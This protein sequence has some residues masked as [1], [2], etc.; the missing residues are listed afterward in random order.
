ME[1][2]VIIDAQK[3]KFEVDLEHLKEEY[4]A[5]LVDQEALYDES[6]VTLESLFNASLDAQKEL[7]DQLISNQKAEYEQA[8]ADAISQ[9]NEELAIQTHDFEVALS[10]LEQKLADLNSKLYIYEYSTF[11]FNQVEDSLIGTLS[12]EL[13]LPNSTTLTVEGIKFTLRHPLTG[14]ISTVN[15]IISVNQFEDISGEFEL[16]VEFHGYFEMTIELTYIDSIGDQGILTFKLPVMYKVDQVNFAW[17]HATMPVLLFASDLLNNKYPGYTYVEIERAATYDFNKLP[18]KALKYPLAVSASGGNYTQTQIPNFYTNVTHG[19]SNKMIEWMKELYSI[20]PNTNFKILGVDNDLTVITSSILSG[21]PFERLS[22][23][24]YTDGS[25]TTSMINS[26]FSTLSQFNSL[27]TLFE[28]WLNG[29]VSG[30][31]I[32]AH[33]QSYYVLTSTKLD[34]FE[35]VVNSISGWNL[36]HDLMELIN[37]ELNVRVLSVSDAFGSLETIGKLDELEYL[38]KT[39][40]GS[41]PNESMMAY[42]TGNPVKNLLILGTSPTGEVNAQ[43]ASFDK[44]LEKIVELYGDEYKIFYKGH[45]RYPSEPQRV[46]LFENNNVIEL[47]N[48]IPVETLML[49]YENVYVGGYNGTSFQSS[50]KDQTVFLFGTQALIKGNAT[51]K[52]LIETTDI[53]SNTVYL[54]VDSNGE[55]VVQ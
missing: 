20:N 49:L 24:I 30:S 52:N 23:V 27:Y 50:L 12:Y 8:L 55:V 31:N 33:M 14:K 43:F 10:R 18:E 11:V 19:Q 34:N 53:F 44:H 21:I 26:S 5:K 6:L 37:D 15:P 1:L 36:E 35:Y 45:P 38:L 28:N 42:F 3:S 29:N 25:F 51:M 16:E 48:S 40:W 17:L 9:F 4:D 41:E 22:F 47:P 46:Q 39:R 7:Y 32:L 54:T 2:R 13:S